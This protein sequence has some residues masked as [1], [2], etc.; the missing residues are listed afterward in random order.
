MAVQTHPQTCN[1]NPSKRVKQKT[2]GS[3][4][5]AKSTMIQAAVTVQASTKPG[6]KAVVIP[7]LAAVKR[8]M[9]LIRSAGVK[10]VDSRFHARSRFYDNVFGNNFTNKL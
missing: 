5:V 9:S 6:Q 3:V 7:T 8:N 2:N 4:K 10:F 1:G